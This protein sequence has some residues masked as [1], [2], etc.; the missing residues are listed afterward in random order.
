MDPEVLAALLA[1]IL[2]GDL[3]SLSDDDLAA[4]E[5]ALLDEF[6]A[7]R[8]TARGADA[9]ATLGQIADAVDALRAEAGVRIDA[10]VQEAEAVAALEARLRPAEPETA[11]ENDPDPEEPGGAAE[12]EAPAEPEEVLETPEPEGEREPALVASTRTPAPPAPRRPSLRTLRSDPPPPAPQGQGIRLANGQPYSRRAMAE[13]AINADRYS[14]A[15]RIGARFRMPI[16]SVERRVDPGMLLTVG[17]SEQNERIINSVI[18]EEAL[19]ASGGFCGPL[20]PYYALPSLGQAGRPVH[21]ALPTF[22]VAERGGVTFAR[23]FEVADFEDG[24]TIWDRDTD[25][26]PGND[27]KNCVTVACTSTV[28]EEILAFVRCVKIGNFQ[29]RYSPEHVA[30][31]MDFVMQQWASQSEVAL[32]DRIKSTT[33]GDGSPAPG[34][35]QITITKALGG[36]AD[37]LYSV[38]VAAAGYRNSSRMLPGV[39]LRGLAPAWILDMMMGDMARASHQYEQQLALNAAAINSYLA[40]RNVRLDFYWDSPSDGTPQ[41]FPLQNDGPLLDYP[42]EIQ[43]GL[44][45]EGSHVV[46]DG[47]PDINFGIV[48]DSVLNSTNDY[49]VFGENFEGYAFMGIKSYW[50]SQ[51]I[52]PNGEF[53]APEDI[54]DL[55]CGGGFAP[56]S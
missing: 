21:D 9:L 6:D 2:G 28:S 23:P 7:Q 27:T 55:V 46:L 17:Q 11:P 19:V 20:T 49:E 10:A 40:A 32:L 52:C 53:S 51:A 31:A 22:S 5:A 4:H 43:W 14:D 47:G 25:T 3:S 50:I 45:A 35:K 12:P 36:V 29:A 24:I 44:W 48:R 8:P 33:N 1:L 38:G 13:C 42:D 37:F 34:K 18:G 30:Q 16:V 15:S 41:T 26:T 39:G 54:S 56:G